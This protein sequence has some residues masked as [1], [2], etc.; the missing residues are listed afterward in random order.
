MDVDYGIS[1][2]PRLDLFRSLRSRDYRIYFSGQ[3]LSVL[4]TWITRIATSWLVYQ[5]IQPADE[6]REAKIL[7]IVAF[8]GLIP[9]LLLAPLAGVFVDRHDRHRVMVVTQGLALLQSA[10]LAFLALTGKITVAQVVVLQVFQGIINAFDAPARQALTVDLVEHRE[11]LSN[12]IA[13][14][15]SMFNAARLIGPVVAGAILARTSAGWCFALDAVSYLAVIASLLMIKVP[16]RPLVAKRS[17][18]FHELREGFLYAFGSGPIRSL[19]LLAA[20]TSMI[21]MSLQTLLPI[22]ATSLTPIRAQ[23][24]DA[25]SYAFLM[26]AMG[27]GALCGT[28]YL[29]HR[30]SVLGLGYVICISAGVLGGAMILFSFMH[31]LLLALLVA[32][33]AGAAMIVTMAGANTILQTLVADSMRGRLMSFFTMAVMGMA[34]FGSLLSWELTA[35]FGASGSVF[36]AGSCS[37]LSALLFASRLPS[38]RPLVRQIYI[39]RGILPPVTVGLQTATEAAGPD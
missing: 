8:A 20:L 37:L 3:G 36:I 25:Y 32:P 14:N 29:A 9:T 28:A 7:A 2:K 26:T 5:L 4:G 18:H 24:D 19:L 33:L 22:F 13:L 10:T 1:E 30:K 35:H 31:H 34:P 15:S 12:A 27:I 21:G 11:D 16:A 23:W 38:M 39:E 6:A 17:G